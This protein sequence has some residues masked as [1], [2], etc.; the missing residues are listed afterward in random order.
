MRDLLSS[1]GLESLL[2]GLGVG[3]TFALTA[4]LGLVGMFFA[5]RSMRQ[6]MRDPEVLAAAD[7][8]ANP[9]RGWVQ[10]ATF[11][12]QRGWDN[13]YAGEDIIR[14]MLAGSWGIRTAEELDAQVDEL[15]EQGDDAM[16]LLRAM[17]LVRSAVAVGWISNDASF[18][19]CY[20]IGTR[21]QARY[22]SWQAMA[23]DA[24]RARREWCGVPLDGSADDEGMAEVAAAAAELARTHWRSIDW[25]LPLQ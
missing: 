21:L 13:A 9:R 12:L 10:G 22:P 1:L 8:Q 7:L 20:A 6:R 23:D 5:F 14:P 25:K 4:A 11:I 16:I 17:L 2:A 19:R 24:L 3:G 15:L 18:Q